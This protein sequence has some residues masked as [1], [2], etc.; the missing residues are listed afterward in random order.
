MEQ[1]GSR[2]QALGTGEQVRAAKTLP[3]QV[4]KRKAQM[5]SGAVDCY[6]CTFLK[7]CKW[8]RAGTSRTRWESQQWTWGDRGDRAVGGSPCEPLPGWPA[9]N[10]AIKELPSG[11]PAQFWTLD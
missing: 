9:G 4:L 8:H 11:D 7:L 10:L 3:F 5:K 6:S 2:T 1:L